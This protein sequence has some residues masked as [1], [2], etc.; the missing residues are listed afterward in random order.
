MKTNE[1]RY[2]RD[3]SMIC[4]E[5]AVIFAAEAQKRRVGVWLMI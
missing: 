3:D 5:L 2:F 1:L 4:K